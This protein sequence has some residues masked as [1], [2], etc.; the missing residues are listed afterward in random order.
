VVEWGGL[1][2]R[3]GLAVTGGSNPPLSAI[4]RF[5]QMTG[6]FA[7]IARELSGKREAAFR[8]TPGLFQLYFEVL[9]EMAEWSKAHDWKS[10]VGQ[11]T[12]GSN[13][14]LSAIWRL[15]QMT[16]SFSQVAWELSGKREAAFQI[17]PHYK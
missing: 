9:G 4:W 16:S 12:V 8:I 2:N 10:C 5:E 1:E 15:E 13:P 17:T 7:Q 11:P 6:S 14:T 3:C